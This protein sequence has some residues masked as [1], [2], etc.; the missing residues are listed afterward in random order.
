MSYQT[1]QAARFVQLA[2]QSTSDAARIVE[3]Q[4]NLTELLGQIH[5]L[6]GGAA[7]GEDKTAAQAI[8]ASCDRARTA[9]NSLHRTA[10]TLRRLAP[11]L[12]Q[13]R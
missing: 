7:G 8:A 11:R 6:I 2:E 5:G 1:P 10:E 4:W 13:N 3:L 12:G 9:N